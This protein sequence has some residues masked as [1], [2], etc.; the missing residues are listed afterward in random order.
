MNPTEITITST[1]KITSVKSSES[2]DSA[3]RALMRAFGLLQ[4]VMNPYFARFGISGSQWAVLRTLQ[5]AEDE[6]I[7]S[8]RLTE[9]S[10]QLLIRPPSV[11]GMI[12]RL[13]R[14]GLVAR[15]A[16]TI[17]LRAKQVSLTDKGRQL[18]QRVLAVHEKQIEK[19]LAGLKSDE[20]IEL[21]RLL[22]RFNGHLQWLMEN[23]QASDMT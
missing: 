21:R 17:D 16:S 13:E 9:L 15:V 8:L 11:T 18:L 23:P 19:V 1:N 4:S 5:R 6:R 22:G 3:V 12:E 14:L 7:S 2:G 20:Q 10:S